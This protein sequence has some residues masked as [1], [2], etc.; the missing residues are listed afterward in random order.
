MIGS[1]FSLDIKGMTVADFLNDRL[2]F[3]NPVLVKTYGTGDGI[4]ESFH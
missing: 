1:R 2:L 4:G 3:G